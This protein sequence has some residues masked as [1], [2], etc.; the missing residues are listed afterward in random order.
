MTQPPNPP[1]IDI[2]DDID[3]MSDDAM[4]MCAAGAKPDHGFLGDGYCSGHCSQCGSDIH[5]SITAPT[6]IPKVCL[7]CG[8]A[9]G[10]GSA[11]MAITEQTMDELIEILGLP[12]TDD[13]REQLKQRFLQNITAEIS[14]RQKNQS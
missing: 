13:V 7:P 5:F 4:M 2:I 11:G 10:G 8:L 6:S 9:S 1:S 3:E 14:R 12:D